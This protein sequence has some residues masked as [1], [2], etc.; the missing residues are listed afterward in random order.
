MNNKVNE[1]DANLP[2]D[3]IGMVAN[4][5]KP[6]RV[7]TVSKSVWPLTINIDRSRTII[8]QTM[9]NVG[10]ITAGAG[11][12]SGSSAA[13]LGWFA[14][15]FKTIAIVAGAS[16]LI[17]AIAKL[18]KTLDKSIKV[19]YNKVVKALQTAQRDFTL[20]PDG[21]NM[22]NILPGYGG[23]G[24]KIGDFASRLFT[25][26]FSKKNS[27]NSAKYNIGL[28]PFCDKYKQEITMD[29]QTAV[30][31]FN[32][33][34]AANENDQNESV[35]ESEGKVYESFHAVL[36]S[37]HLNEGHESTSGQG[38]ALSDVSLK[39]GQFSYKGET[40]QLNKESV[41]EIC[42]SIIYNYADKYVN[43]DRVFKDLGISSGSLSDLDASSVDKL[44]D[45]LEKYSKPE[46]NKYGK[47]YSRIKEGYDSMLKHYYS[48]GDGIIKNFEKFTEAKDE[49]KSNLLVASKEKLQNMWDS[50]KDVY[51]K[52][53]SHVL[54]EIISS[55]AYIG[56]LGFILQNV[57]PVFKSGLAGDVDY[58]LDMMPVKGQYYVT[59]QTNPQGV[60]GDQ[61]GQDKSKGNVAIVKV[62]SFDSEKKE[63]KFSLLGSLDEGRG[64][65]IT[66]GFAHITSGESINFD[67]YKDDNG[68]KKEV[69]LPYGKWLGLDPYLVMNDD[70]TIGTKSPLYK[71]EIG[72]G[73]KKETQYIY[74][75]GTGEGKAETGIEEYDTVYFA[76]YNQ[77][78]SGFTK[79][80]KLSMQHPIKK[81]EFEKLVT[82]T[83]EVK[84]NNMGFA[85]DTV[86][87]DE[88]IKRIS[89]YVQ[90]DKEVE[91]KTND[92]IV[93]LI[94]GGNEEGSG[95]K[96]KI[97]NI[98]G[99]ENGEYDEYIFA[100]IPINTESVDYSNMSHLNDNTINE[101]GEGE[102]NGEGGEN[103]GN[104][105]TEKATT[106][107]NTEDKTK[108]LVYYR[109]KSGKK[110][111]DGDADYSVT[112]IPLEPE[113]SIKEFG[114]A[115]TGLEPVDE[116]K[117]AVS[118]EEL[119][120]EVKDKLVQDANEKKLKFATNISSL[121]ETYKKIL[122]GIEK[123]KTS[124]EELYKKAVEKINQ[125][126]PAIFDCIKYNN[127]DKKWHLEKEVADGENKGFVAEKVSG[128]GQE[129]QPKIT[130]PEVIT[131]WIGSTKDQ[132]AALLTD[133]KLNGQP[134]KFQDA[135]GLVQAIAALVKLAMEN[136]SGK[137]ISTEIVPKQNG[138]EQNAQKQEQPAQGNE[139]GGENGQQAP[140]QPGT[141]GDG[142]PAGGE[143]K[144]ESFAV[145]YSVEKV[146]DESVTIK[147]SFDNYVSPKWYILS[148]SIFDDGSSRSS[149]I[150]SAS[151]REGLLEKDDVFAYVKSR[152][153]VS[154]TE[155]ATVGTF[156]V[157]RAFG[158][159]PSPATPLYESAMLIKFAKNGTVEQKVYLG[160]VRIS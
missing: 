26:N 74:A 117:F 73:N 34:K 49:K 101:A 156:S 18:I 121:A 40:V 47:Q 66:D 13:G 28:H 98:Y 109:Y 147:R 159:V 36:E 93:K 91:I 127:E 131:F 140:A 45:I 33:I 132:A 52:N 9:K 23:L 110:I 95:A 41:R 113:A 16:A 114:D 53:F 106:P 97:S 115:V 58:V 55:D 124:P 17:A 54:I 128:N 151:F 56:Y 99:R 4:V 118:S 59:R 25:L 29:Y 138:N 116:K 72:E 82:S 142:A 39:G 145:E 62:L 150:D 48:I 153:N 65:S 84:V 149:R 120:D 148:E 144:V 119:A 71:R 6:A 22:K 1:I 30:D 88:T 90:Q 92:E 14:A 146:L 80:V 75:T 102:G 81:D 2:V 35:K 24:A 42:Y 31:A 154:L 11:G 87:P 94:N 105:D 32:K 158:Y 152:K 7:A 104:G 126:A 60:I 137:K 157:E 123:G 111:T 69:T 5:T 141:S 79:A 38:F 100:V 78:Y 43:M 133:D 103:S 63:I 10:N 61:L 139:N 20:S 96:Y 135:N 112:G 21:M 12:A 86:E 19:R 155:G 107:D 15:N 67:A 51:N 136:P 160:K 46:G 83:D 37:L 50:Q 64:L 76:I 143:A 129:D 70:W 130:I 125:V 108:F 3:T 77:K 134:T 122:E 57:L 89:G 68:A 85:E 44:H 8:T 27:A